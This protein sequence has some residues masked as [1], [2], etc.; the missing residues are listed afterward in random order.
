MASGSVTSWQIDRETMQTVTDFIFRAPKSLQM[1]F[2]AMKLKDTYSL[3]GQYDQPRQHIKKQRHY[4][5]NQSPSSQGYGFSSSHVWMW[6][7][8]NEKVWVWTNWCLQTVLL[9]KMLE[10]PLNSKQI[11]SVNSKGNQPWICIERSGV[12]VEAPNLWPPDVKSWLIEKTLMLGKIEGRRRRERQRIRL[13]D[14]ITDSMDMSL[15]MLWEL[16]DREAW[17]AAVHGVA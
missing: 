11:K 14:G 8:D 6:K 5:F 12:E 17:C 9:E 2:A 3:E 13:L 10:S 16:M 15:S 4:F 1:V 7:L